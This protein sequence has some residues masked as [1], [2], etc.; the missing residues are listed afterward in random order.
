MVNQL[1]GELLTTT[2]MQIE[3]SWLADTAA[4]VPSRREAQ[5]HPMIVLNRTVAAL[6]VSTAHATTPETKLPDP[7]LNVARSRRPRGTMA[8]SNSSYDEAP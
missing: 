6:G 4:A 8:S 7:D 5:C 1:I 3:D 2:E